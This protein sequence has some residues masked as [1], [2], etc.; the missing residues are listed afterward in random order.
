MP[1]SRYTD[2]VA[3]LEIYDYTAL[4]KH[5]PSNIATADTQMT[6]SNARQV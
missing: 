3:R 4:T 6:N 1:V 5:E 2:Y